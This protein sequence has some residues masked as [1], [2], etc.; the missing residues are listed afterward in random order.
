MSRAR[1]RRDVGQPDRF[2]LVTLPLESEVVSKLTGGAAHQ[3]HGGEALKRIH[4]AVRIARGRSRHVRQNDDRELEAFRRVHGHQAHA[5]GPGLVDRSFVTAGLGGFVLQRF[6]ESAKGQ[7]PFQFEG[8]RNIRDPLHVREGSSSGRAQ[9]QTDVRAGCLEQAMNCVGKRAVVSSFAQL[10][11]QLQRFGDRGEIGREFRR[12]RGE[13]MQ[14]TLRGSIAQQVRVRDRQKRA[15]KRGVDR[16]FV[17]GPFDRG[18]NGEQGVDLWAIS[19]G[20]RADED[21]GQAARV[22]RVGVRLGAVGIEGFEPA[23]QDPDVARLDGASCVGVVLVAYGPAAV[24]AQPIEPGRDQVWLTRVGGR[25][26]RT[27][28]AV[29]ERDRE[30]DQRGLVIERGR[31]AGQRMVAGLARAKVLLH[32]R[33]EGE[34]DGVLDS[35]VRAKTPNEMHGAHAVLLKLL[36]NRLIEG[37]VRAPE[38]VDAL[39]RVPDDE[40]LAGDRSNAP[41]VGLLR[42][43][44][45]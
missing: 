18:Q 36:A 3:P 44:R 41:P 26:G 23:E 22:E 19:K 39:L 2:R 31:A 35:A 33:F 29:H 42:V 8:S 45:A 1:R 12:R 4:M 11:Q 43:V 34:I 24:V 28:V 15:P 14:A 7:P 25:P 40:Q 16:K 21:M 20:P 37:H 32:L 38:A 6:N 9:R 17:F 13:W 27:L 30:R 5:F 10:A